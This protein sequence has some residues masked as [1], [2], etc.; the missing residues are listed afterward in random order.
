MSRK[1]DIHVRKTLLFIFLWFIVATMDLQKYIKER[2]LTQQ[3]AANGIGVSRPYL[4][5]ILNKKAVPGRAIAFKIIAWS[6]NMVRFDDL[7]RG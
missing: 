3:E 7:W 2:R 5:D 1:K 4:C 6:N